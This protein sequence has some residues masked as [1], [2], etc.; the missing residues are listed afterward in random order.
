MSNECVREWSDLTRALIGADTYGDFTEHRGL[1]NKNDSTSIVPIIRTKSKDGVK[2]MTITV[3][4]LWKRASPEV[5]N[6]MCQYSVRKA[7]G[8]DDIRFGP[9]ALD[10]IRRY[11]SPARVDRLERNFVEFKSTWGSHLYLDMDTR[12]TKKI[13]YIIEKHLYDIKVMDTIHI[14]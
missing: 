6:E 4:T 5:L 11:A 14:R 2:G 7:L 12:V 9:M 10:Y 1:M 13:K 8:M 3:S